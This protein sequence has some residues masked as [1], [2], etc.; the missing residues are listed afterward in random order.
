MKHYPRTL[1]APDGF[2]TVTVQNA[3]QEARVRARFAGQSE[4]EGKDASPK[5]IMRRKGRNTNVRKP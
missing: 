4:P 5:P 2:T 1:F 3:E